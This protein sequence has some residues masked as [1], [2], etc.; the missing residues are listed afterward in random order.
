MALEPRTVT[1]E[2]A[3]NPELVSMQ[4]RPSTENALGR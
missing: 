4:R 2:E 3:E 1:A